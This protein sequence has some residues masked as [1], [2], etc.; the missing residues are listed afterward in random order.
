M[1]YPNRKTLCVICQ[2]SYQRSLHGICLKCQANRKTCIFCEEKPQ[3]SDDHELCDDCWHWHYRL[4]FGKD[5]ELGRTRDKAKRRASTNRRN[6]ERRKLGIT[7]EKSEKNRLAGNIRSRLNYHMKSWGLKKPGSLSA[8]LGC[9][10]EHLKKHLEG[11]FHCRVNGEKMAWDNY[12][13]HGWHVDHRRPLCSFNMENAD[14]AKEA[15]HFS[16]LQPLWAED[17]LKKAT[18]DRRKTI[19]RRSPI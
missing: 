18:I 15:V 17:N 4:F 9:S 2:R 19:T 12:G 14:Q 10:W 8:L 13:V 11:Q 1:K 7:N 6:K 5:M 16:N 3:R